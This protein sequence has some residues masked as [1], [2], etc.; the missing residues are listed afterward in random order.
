MRRILAYAATLEAVG[1]VHGPGSFTGVRVGLSAAKGLCE[2]GGAALIAMS[3][4]ELVALE[5]GQDAALSVLDAGRG[6]FFCGFYRGGVLEREEILKR[7]A[8]LEMAHGRELL[9]CEPRVHQALAAELTLKLIAEPGA[10]AMLRLATRRIERGQW[11]D[12]ATTD[13]NYLRR[14]DAELLGELK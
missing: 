13:A 7:P 4:L 14:T 9:T 1:V 5:A 10:A 3:R 12:I 6:E 2:A 8:L 11:S